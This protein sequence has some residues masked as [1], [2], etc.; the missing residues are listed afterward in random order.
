MF[1]I[2]R[3]NVAKS[4]F[5]AYEA[6]VSPQAG[7][8]D[9]VTDNTGRESV[10]MRNQDPKLD[11]KGGMIFMVSSGLVCYCYSKAVLVVVIFKLL[12]VFF[13]EQN[14][15]CLIVSQ[16]WIH[17]GLVAHVCAGI[18]VVLCIDQVRRA[19]IWYGN[20]SKTAPSVSRGVA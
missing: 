11:R 5:V 20:R 18:P 3:K 1:V 9:T 16:D 2:S 15:T 6:M 8:P 10:N 4:S 19:F 12:K 14:P 7:A 17:L 13:Y